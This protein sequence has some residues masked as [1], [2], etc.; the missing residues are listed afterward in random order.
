[1][2]YI[3]IYHRYTKIKLTCICI[4]VLS[5]NI[6]IIYIYTFIT[7]CLQHLLFG[8]S[9]DAVHHLRKGCERQR[10]SARKVARA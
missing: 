1:M 2:Q 3:Y 7:F 4:Y 9:P 6:F 8:P 10:R 5:E